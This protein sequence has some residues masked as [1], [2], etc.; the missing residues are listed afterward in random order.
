MTQES[1]FREVDI[2]VIR[3]VNADATRQAAVVGL[4][5][6]ARASNDWVIAEGVETEAERATL[7]R[8]KVT[9]AQGYLFSRPQTIEVIEY[10]ASDHP[11]AA[12]LMRRSRF[13]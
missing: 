8:L 2:S 6:F 9:F 1:G 11:M 10:E 3:Q 7:A 4:L 5:H 13:S 12:S